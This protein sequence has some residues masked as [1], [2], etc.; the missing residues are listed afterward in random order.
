MAKDS[1]SE[2]IE[3]ISAAAG[4]QQGQQFQIQLDDAQTPVTYSTTARV[5]GSPEEIY[6]DFAGP[7][8]P[9]SNNT[10]RLKVDQRVVLS[11]W[12]AKR[13]A[14]ALNQAIVRYEQTYGSL[15]I[16]ARRRVINQ[17]IGGAGTTSGNA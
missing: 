1:G 8:R 13:L 17:P 9:T 15:E 12:A 6:L 16:D 4:E 11:P 5:W 2:S 10:A 7:L 3:T 14:L